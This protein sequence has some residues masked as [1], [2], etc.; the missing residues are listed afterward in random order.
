MFLNNFILWFRDGCL[1]RHCNER[2]RHARASIEAEW[3]M[4]SLISYTQH[5]TP[6]PQSLVCAIGDVY[7]NSLPS[8]YIVRTDFRT[9][10]YKL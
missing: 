8:R 9:D 7:R 2:R 5:T 10:M 3:Q 1:L 6:S 4:G